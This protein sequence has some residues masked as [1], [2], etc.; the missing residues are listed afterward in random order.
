MRILHLSDTHGV[1]PAPETDDWDVAVHSGDIMPNASF[2]VASVEQS[3]QPR[4]LAE[5]V[6]RFPAAYRKKPFLLCLGNHDFIDP[7]SA[8]RAAG[9]DAHLLDGLVEVGGVRFYGHRWTPPFYDWAWMCKPSEMALKLKPLRAAL[10]G[11][12]VD[13]LVSHGPMRGVLDRNAD[14]ERCGC[15]KLRDTLRFGLTLP[16]A[17]LCGHIH[18]S[19]GLQRWDRSQPLGW[20]LVSNAACTQRVVEV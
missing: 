4:W 10:D 5:N 11:G 13:I 18:K 17:M 15:P 9:I 20:M 6:A 16:K 2:G 8:L 19:P 1:P 14:G 12:L 3:F 7:T